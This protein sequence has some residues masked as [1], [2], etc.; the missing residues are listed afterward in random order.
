MGVKNSRPR[1]GKEVR[2][3]P[4][5]QPT[6]SSNA[7]GSMLSAPVS[8]VRVSIP[9]LQPPPLVIDTYRHSKGSNNGS[10]LICGGAR[11]TESREIC[12]KGASDTSFAASEYPC[13]TTDKWHQCLSSKM[14]FCLSSPIPIYNNELSL[15]TQS[16]PMLRSYRMHSFSSQDS[17][18]VSFASPSLSPSPIYARFLE[19][20]GYPTGLENY[21][22]TCYCNAVLQLLYH[23]S[24]L[25]LRLLELN[26]IYEKGLGHTGFEDGTLLALVADLFA[27]LHK[28]NNHKKQQREV[29]APRALLT[30]IRKQNATFNNSFQHD[31]HEFAMFLLSSMIETETRMMGD[32]KNRALFFGAKISKR[33]KWKAMLRRSRKLGS[34]VESLGLMD[35]REE[36]L[37][38]P[39]AL[40]E[41][42]RAPR[43]EASAMNGDAFE[44]RSVAGSTGTTTTGADVDRSTASPLQVIFG[45]QFISLT[46]C[47][48]CEKVTMMREAFVDLSLDVEQ[49]SSLLRC[50]ANFGSPELFHGDNTLYCDHCQKQVVAQKL[51]RVHRLPEYAL[52]VHLKRFEYNEK[53][54]SMMKRSDHIALP[55]EIDVVEYEPWEDDDNANTQ[56]ASGGESRAARSSCSPSMAVDAVADVEG[57]AAGGIPRPSSRLMKKLNGVAHRKGRFALSGFVTHVGSGPTLGHYF[58]CVRMGGRWLLFNDD[59]VSEM[60]EYEMQHFWGVPIPVSEVVT[61]TAYILLYERVA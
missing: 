48:E 51:L 44:I 36:Y 35:L 47:L 43:P 58:T 7:G 55:S 4:R 33:P 30:C 1:K 61:A 5:E 20:N 34:S 49:G 54:G 24:P 52:L 15:A 45:G 12:S 8:A 2:P 41:T 22:N 21:G 32:E 13:S 37:E 28:A 11:E 9:S 16:T 27:K 42:S 46:A 59:S 60:T 53:R 31:A 57:D 29:V 50:M 18:Q 56:A 10:E 3:P 39:P 23:C 19:I 38:L 14:S 17:T 6:T 26:Q 40:R 25:R